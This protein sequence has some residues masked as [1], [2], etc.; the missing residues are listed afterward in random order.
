MVRDRR[1]ES[2]LLPRL[3]IGPWRTYL[4]SHI[5]VGQSYASLAIITPCVRA[6]GDCLSAGS[7]DVY[8]WA[9]DGC[10]QSGWFSGGGV[11][12]SIHS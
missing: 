3:R 8:K 9:N 4:S 5:C 11:A 7:D 2:R 10:M 12:P 6:D 1:S